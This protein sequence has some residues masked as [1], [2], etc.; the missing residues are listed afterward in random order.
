[1]INSYFSF[2]NIRSNDLFGDDLLI[3][4]KH[5]DFPTLKDYST[6]IPF[7]NSSI[8]YSFINGPCYNNRNVTIK[9]FLDASSKIKLKE[10]YSKL[11]NW[12]SGLG[13]KLVFSDI[14]G[15]YYYAKLTSITSDE[16]YYKSSVITMA[17]SC[18]PYKL[19]VNDGYYSETIKEDKIISL[20]NLTM[21][22]VPT[23]EVDRSINIK[24]NNKSYSLTSG[25]NEIYDITFKE[26]VNNIE[27][28]PGN[29]P[30]NVKITYQRGEL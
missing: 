14:Q 28:I 13:S 8:D 25:V 27:F 11:Q 1:M 26:G 10:R 29:N 20:M 22:T 18:K 30:T 4:E 6:D 19:A 15:F 17:F 7:G 5:I 12:L 9:I 24:F 3:L 21:P 16:E 2:K 23:I